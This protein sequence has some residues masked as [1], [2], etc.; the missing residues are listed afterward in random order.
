MFFLLAQ[1][2]E[3][4]RSMALKNYGVNPAHYRTLPG[5][6]WDALL[7]LS[8]MKVDLISDP[9]IYLFLENSIRGGVST[10]SNRYASA[11]DPRLPTFDS[12]KPP[13]YITYLD[14]N[15]LYGHAMTQALPL[16][17]FRFLS[18]DE[19]A[20]LDIDS[21]SDDASQGYIFEVDL[22]H[23]RE[24]HKLHSDF[25]VAPQRVKVTADMLSPYCKS[26]AHG[27]ILTKKLLPN[28]YDKVKYVTHYRNL[29][30]Y[31]RLGLTITAVHRVLTFTQSPWM[32]SFIQLNTK[33]RQQAKSEFEKD[34][35][36]VMNNAVFGESMENVRN[37]HNFHW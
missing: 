2:F 24:L 9:E 19:I 13:S 4:F 5:F 12:T 8:G 36:K 23:P 18:C 37:R 16:G 29:K 25:S 30:L 22:S 26:L 11:N 31:K 32:R 1:V 3:T 27:H 10:I 21:L 20:R 33:L 17:D 14:V 35:F 15:N 7:K 34:S 28:L 6:S